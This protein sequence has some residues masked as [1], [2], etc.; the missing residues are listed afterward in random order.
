MLLVQAEKLREFGFNDDLTGRNS[1]EIEGISHHLAVTRH[2]W[3]CV[4][5]LVTAIRDQHGRSDKW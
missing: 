5:S 3:A 4:L 1:R 2:S